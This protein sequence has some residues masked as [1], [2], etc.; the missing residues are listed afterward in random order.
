MENTFIGFSV[1]LVV[2]GVIVAALALTDNSLSRTAECA[3]KQGVLVK[4]VGGESRCIKADIIEIV[5]K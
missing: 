4:I 2:F 5:V 1:G 3:A